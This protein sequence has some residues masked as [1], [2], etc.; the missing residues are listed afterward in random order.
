M[1]VRALSALVLV[2]VVALVLLATS[3]LQPIEVQ[4]DAP[5]ARALRSEMSGLQQALRRQ[6]A[7][8]GEQA[9]LL[10]KLRAA[11]V[12]L[13][14]AAAA[15]PAAAA[16]APA[17]A[18]AAAPAAVAA[19]VATAAP[20]T[21]FAPPLAES[22]AA[23]RRALAGC[24]EADVPMLRRLLRSPCRDGMHGFDCD[25]RWDLE[26]RFLPPSERWQAEWRAAKKAVV[27]CQRGFFAAFEEV[28]AQLFCAIILRN[29]SAKK[30]P[31]NS[32]TPPPPPPRSG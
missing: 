6:Q 19:A 17:V 15:A 7:A 26:D 28:R 10:E 2:L 31:R 30:S 3:K 20:A 21:P 14:A 11:A 13:P 23:G 1:A 8:A 16:T 25:V 5:L 32:L 24:A 4:D 12:A 22:L 9:A 18:P 27:D 29:Y